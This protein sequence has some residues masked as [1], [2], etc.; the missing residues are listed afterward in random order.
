MDID[1]VIHST[2]EHRFKLK[3]LHPVQEPVI[4]ACL[5]GH[6]C[7]TTM[8]TGGRKSLCYQRS[9]LLSN[10]VSIV[11]S[12]LKS[13]IVEQVEALRRLQVIKFLRFVQWS[14]FYASLVDTQIPATYISSLQTKVEQGK[15]VSHIRP[16]ETGECQTLIVFHM[17]VTIFL[18]S[19]SVQAPVHHT[20]ATRR[21]LAVVT[22]IKASLRIEFD[23][24]IRCWRGPLC[25]YVGQGLPVRYILSQ[26]KKK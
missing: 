22:V 9:A 2:L 25:F 23:C 15:I 18:F 8:P 5:M 6:D 17:Q 11:I 1:S 19:N 24:Q 13:L 16:L 12:P 10:G 26:K 21:Q 14:M 3:Q 4:K 20:G 7:F